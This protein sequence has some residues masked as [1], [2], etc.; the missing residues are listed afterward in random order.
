M[1]TG[2]DWPLFD[3][4]TGIYERV[5]KCGYK[6]IPQVCSRL[7]G[8]MQQVGAIGIQHRSSW[9]ERCG[10]CI[11]RE[12]MVFTVHWVRRGWKTFVYHMY[13]SM[14]TPSFSTTP[15][16][17][18]WHHTTSYGTLCD[19]PREVACDRD[20]SGASLYIG[21]HVLNTCVSFGTL[22][23]WRVYQPRSA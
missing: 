22:M 15:Y 10:G 13:H 11:S 16:D 18:L 21:R 12:N 14:A 5:K 2:A 4:A 8:G 7:E 17:T 9:I 6:R 1:L 20:H 3:T 19:T 23:F